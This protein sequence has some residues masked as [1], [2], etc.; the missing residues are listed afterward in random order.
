MSGTIMTTLLC[1]VIGTPTKQT[2]PVEIEPDKLWGHVKDA[3]KEEKKNEFADIDADVLDLWKVLHCG[4]SHVVM[5]NSQFKGHHRSFPAFPL[6]I[7][8]FLEE[9]YGH[10]PTRSHRIFVKGPQRPTSRRSY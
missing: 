3:I 9:S 10:K 8:R 7:R 6:G 2:F 1:W 4:I 5:L